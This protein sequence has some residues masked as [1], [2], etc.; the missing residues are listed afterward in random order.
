MNPAAVISS[1]V[2][3]SRRMMASAI[4]ELS[5]IERPISPCSSRMKAFA[6]CTAIGWSRPRRRCN[7]STAAGSGATPP[8][9][10]SNSAGSPGTK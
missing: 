7:A 2:R 8:E 1:R 10:R 3:G 4:E 6:Y 9:E 5:F